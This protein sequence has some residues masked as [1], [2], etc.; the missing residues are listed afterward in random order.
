MIKFLHR[1]NLLNHVHVQLSLNHNQVTDIDDLMDLQ[2]LNYLDLSRNRLS[3]LRPIRPMIS[4]RRLLLN[5]NNLTDL[6]PLADHPNLQHLSLSSNLVSDI[7]PLSNLQKL[8]HLDASR[9][10]IEVKSDWNRRVVRLFSENQVRTRFVE[11]GEMVDG[12]LQLAQALISDKASNSKL[13]AYLEANGY[14]RLGDYHADSNLS[15]ANKTTS[16]LTWTKA[17]HEDKLS[18]LPKLR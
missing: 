12:L 8:N 5:G 16:Y 3:D 2:S 6:R 1:Q 10:L 9:N 11:Q 14:Q 7:R 15:A 17:I 4:L 18:N 13:A